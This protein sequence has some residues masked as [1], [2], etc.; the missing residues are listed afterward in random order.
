MAPGRDRT[1]TTLEGGERS[2]H[3]AVLVRVIDLIRTSFGQ[4]PFGNGLV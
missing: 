4:G 1:G 2:H 3:H